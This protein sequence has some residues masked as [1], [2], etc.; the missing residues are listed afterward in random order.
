MTENLNK[1]IIIAT[2]IVMGTQ[3]LKNCEYS[4]TSSSD[5]EI[6]ELLLL[7]KF[8]K[9]KKIQRIE[10]Y[11]EKV[12]SNYTN[13]QFQSH[14]RI[15]RT[16]FEVLLTILGPNLE[17]LD[18]GRPT[19][20]VEK[21][22]LSVIWLL[23]TPDSYRSV[24]ERFD[25]S[26]STLFAC[27]ER[28][29]SALNSVSSQ[30]ICWPMQEELETIKEKFK[31]MAGIDGV[32]AAIDGTYVPIKA[33]LKNPD[34]Y[35]TRK[36][37]YAITLQAMC[38]CDMK[39]VDCF[40]GY[41]GSVHDARIFR[42]S[43]IYHLI[44]EN[45]KKYFPRNEFILADKAYPVSNWCIPPYIDRGNLTRAQRHFNESVSKT[46]QTIERAFALLFGRFRRLKY[47]DMNRIDMIPATVIACCV[48]HNIC[49]DSGDDFLN[50]YINEGMNDVQNER[51]EI[52]EIEDREIGNSRRDALCR[53]LYRNLE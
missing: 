26:K 8:A 19:T 39:F 22:L 21:Q 33:P 34:V 3:L 40:V 41:P 9:R 23:A 35:I 6:E 42:N 30:V 44:C 20:S 45:V 13:R 25:I 18:T 2:A 31:A 15:T 46:R 12:V 27:F 29:I 32:V 4:D 37:Q 16:A 10:R 51:E 36:C 38:D 48:L 11:I 47:L 24:G 52:T 49:I 50:K 53:E 5:S 1:N 43:D 17:N 7:K 14:F 28:V